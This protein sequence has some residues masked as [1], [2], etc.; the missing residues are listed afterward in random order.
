VIEEQR[1]EDGAGRTPRGRELQRDRR[2]GEVH[3]E[4]VGESGGVNPGKRR[5]K[6][7]KRRRKSKRK[8]SRRTWRARKEWQGRGV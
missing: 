4:I 8:R 7:S 3:R 6:K 2:G 1:T 5:S